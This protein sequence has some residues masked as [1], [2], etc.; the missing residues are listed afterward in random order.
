MNFFLNELKTEWKKI[1]EYVNVESEYWVPGQAQLEVCPNG[2]ELEI[3][4]DTPTKW[5]RISGRDA[6]R[7]TRIC[8]KHGFAI[9]YAITGPTALATKWNLRN[10]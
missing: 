4:E 7:Q 8:R 3:Y 2:C 1:P 9:I 5:G 6:Y 10:L